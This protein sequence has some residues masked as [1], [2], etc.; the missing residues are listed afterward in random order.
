MTAMITTV[1]ENEVEIHLY[2]DWANYLGKLL[3]AEGYTIKASSDYSDIALQYFN[4]RQRKIAPATRKF[5]YSKEFT[6]PPEHL[7]GLE[8]LQK[9]SERGENLLPHQSR[10]LK[11][12]GKHEYDRMLFDWGI[13]HLHLGTKLLPNKLVEGFGPV[14]FCMV[15]S[16]TVY[17]IDIRS[18]GR[19]RPN[20][21]GEK[22]LLEIVNSNWSEIISGSR[23]DA[24][25]IFPNLTEPSQILRMRN[26]GLIM[27]VQLL[28]GTVLL[29]PGGGIASAGNSLNASLSHHHHANH[30]GNYMRHIRDNASLF[31]QKIQQDSNYF[32]KKFE[33]RLGVIDNAWIVFE[34]HSGVGFIQIDG[35][36]PFF[37]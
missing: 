22:D 27:G 12:P 13:H 34:R 15:R 30:L 7:I 3:K 6:C 1:D 19:D 21:W 35:L 33:F 37:K 5:L 28:D 9:K 20:V 8:T 14:L 18:H 26:A 17:C 10:G 2:T 16:D 11:K 4:A 31:I 23:T 36:A 24:T 25:S 32:G 29:P